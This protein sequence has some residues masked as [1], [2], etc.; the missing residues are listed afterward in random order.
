MA[1]ATTKD[2]I[3]VI[4]SAG[5]GLPLT[6]LSNSRV[7]GTY[8]STDSPTQTGLAMDRFRVKVIRWVAEGAV[9]GNNVVLT[10]RNGNKVWESTA[11]AANFTDQTNLENDF[12]NGLILTVMDA[13]TLYLYHSI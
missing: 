6:I 3:T 10:D 7:G 1:V 12:R 13:G 9:A 2:N 5:G 8:G 11:T 4:E